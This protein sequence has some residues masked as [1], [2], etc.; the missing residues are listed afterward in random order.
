MWGRF[1]TLGCPRCGA[2]L[3]VFEDMNQFGCAAC[4]SSITVE[5]RSGA[6]GLRVAENPQV[7]SGRIG[8]TEFELA[9]V[10]LSQEL[11][12]LTAL[13]AE[14]NLR[15]SGHKELYGE[16][17]KMAARIAESRRVIA[18]APAARPASAGNGIS[19]TVVCMQCGKPVA[20]HSG[21]CQNCGTVLGS[22]TLQFR[23]GPPSTG[24]G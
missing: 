15:L 3:D 2:R 1:V 6:I 8:T 20:A 23:V 13:V 17:Q 10:G 16:I 19:P 9:L 5:R 18:S 4:G 7:H 24:R 12:R 22:S 11:F 21:T 14:R